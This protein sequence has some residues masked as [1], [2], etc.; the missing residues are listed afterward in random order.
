M[1][2][3][4]FIFAFPENLAEKIHNLGSDQLTL[5]LSN[6][7]PATDGVNAST[8]A[9]VIATVSE[10]VYTGLSSRNLTLT[11][12]LQTSGTY[13]LVLQNLVL[14]ASGAIPTFRYIYV[15][16]S[17]AAAGNLIDVYDYG[18]GITMATSDTFTT[19]WSGNALTI[20]P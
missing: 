15:Y 18:S 14:T 1:T 8:A 6:T 10:I 20:G 12:S 3:P 7:A 19:T 13:A 9:G 17:T 11:S 5:A 4:A 2:A 16:N